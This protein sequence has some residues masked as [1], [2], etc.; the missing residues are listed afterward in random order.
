M[1]LLKLQFFNFLKYTW[2]IFSYK[3]NANLF[4]KKSYCVLQKGARHN[5]LIPKYFA[6]NNLLASFY[7]DFHS[8]HFIFKLFEF[9]PNIFLTKD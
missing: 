9:I 8:S 4:E 1:I 5:Y 6:M 7:T 3:K 2:N